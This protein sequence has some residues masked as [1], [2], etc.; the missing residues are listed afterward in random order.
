MQLRTLSAR[1]CLSLAGSPTID[2]QEYVTFVLDS[3]DPFF[4]DLLAPGEW[5]PLPYRRLGAIVFTIQQNADDV[6]TGAVN[7][8]ARQLTS[9]A[10]AT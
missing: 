1:A 3:Q 10:A 2:C 7:V 9:L 5:V 6:A 8:C 4:N